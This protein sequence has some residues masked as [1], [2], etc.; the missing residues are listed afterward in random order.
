MKC[1]HCFPAVLY[2]G[3]FVFGLALAAPSTAQD[4]DQEYNPP[5]APTDID[6]LQKP[7][8]GVMTAVQLPWRIGLYDAPQKALAKAVEEL[9]TGDRKD[10]AH[11]LEEA[12]G[13]LKSAIDRGRQEEPR[14]PWDRDAEG[15]L[16]A[17]ADEL[18]K[19]VHSLQAGELPTVDSLRPVFGRYL[20]ALARSHVEA[21]SELWLAQ[22]HD[23]AGYEF[24]AA[25]RDIE[26]ALAWNDLSKDEG[27]AKLLA[28]T[29]RVGKELIEGK[30]S[31]EKAAMAVLVSSLRETLRA[32][33]EALS[34]PRSPSPASSPAK[35]GS[36]GIEQG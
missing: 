32:T 4:K 9:E 6:L 16:E 34:A 29:E 31:E 2:F 35:G 1:S 10:A 8:G 36:S 12:R 14:D 24:Q 11:H 27:T 28:E 33:A 22:T 30:K 5:P 20:L 3:V 13:Y 18:K 21:G 19:V 25:A 23:L 26:H 7:K 17:S 15:R